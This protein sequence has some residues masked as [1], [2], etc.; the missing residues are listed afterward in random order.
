MPRRSKYGAR[1]TTVDGIMFHSA[2]EARRWQELKLL[3]RGRAVYDLRR[4]VPFDLVAWARPGEVTRSHLIGSFIADFVYIEN[5]EQIVED[6][7]GIITPLAR[8]K[9]KH[10]RAQYGVKVRI[11]GAASRKLARAA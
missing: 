4:Q 3:E 8:W 9:L 5:G 7:K 1:R 11:T 6:F 2:G 10:F